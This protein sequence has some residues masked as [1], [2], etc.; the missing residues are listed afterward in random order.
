MKSSQR[1]RQ[2]RLMLAIALALL[3]PVA[4]IYIN[5]VSEQKAFFTSRG[6]RQLGV[7]SRQ[8]SSRLDTLRSV[9]SSIVTSVDSYKE[10]GG[11]EHSLTATGR[12]RQL[13]KRAAEV[14][15]QG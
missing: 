7:I 1:F 12:A 3:A 9:L 2:L 15:G 14:A 5:Y 13:E 4:V 8:I 6:F 11:D 10:N